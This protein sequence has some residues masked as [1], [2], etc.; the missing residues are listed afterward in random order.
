MI[1]QSPIGKERL[2]MAK[3]ETSVSKIR[4]FVKRLRTQFAIDKA[5]FFGS[6]A[7]GD[8]LQTSDYDIILV[9]RDFEGIFFT[10]RMALVYGFW[11]DP[12]VLEPL[13]YTPEEFE[14]KKLQIGIVR[15]AIREGIVI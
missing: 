6:R 15:Q 10:E 12:A 8:N 9:S 13:C 14:R 11:D 4:A 1:P 2:E 7:R 5:I 3:T